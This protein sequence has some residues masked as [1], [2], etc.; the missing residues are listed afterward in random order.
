MRTM[1][2]TLAVCAGM[3]LNQAQAEVVRY[4]YAPDA[5]GS[6][7]LVPGPGGAPGE[8]S[9]W[10]G[11]PPSPYP[12]QAIATHVVTFRHSYTGQNVNVPITFPDS[13]ARMETVPEYVQFNFTSYQIRVRFIP[14]GTVDVTYNSGWLRPIA[15]Q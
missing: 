5:C 9:S 13:G 2:L 3:C 11:G 1:V 14:D 10:L 12:R 4:R 15:F 7:Q 6:M 8:R